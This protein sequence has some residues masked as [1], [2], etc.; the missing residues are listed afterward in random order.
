MSDVI[1]GIDLGTTNSVVA[2]IED[3]EPRILAIG[4]SENYSLCCGLFKGSAVVG[5]PA[6]LES[7]YPRPG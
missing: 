2:V 3:G 5:G 1:I 6:R 7:I 4:R